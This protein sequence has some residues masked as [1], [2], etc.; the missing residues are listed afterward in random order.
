M[1]DQLGFEVQNAAS[2]TVEGGVLAGAVSFVAATGGSLVSTIT[3]STPLRIAVWDTTYA[4]PSLAKAADKYEIVSA[5]DWDPPPSNTFTIA[6][7]KDGT[8]DI[9]WPTSAGEVWQWDVVVTK[10]MWDD[11]DAKIHLLS[12]GD[13]EI[14]WINVVSDH[15]ATGDGDTDDKAAINLAIGAASSA[16]GGVIYFPAGDYKVSSAA[17]DSIPANTTLI[18]DGP[19]ATIL[20]IEMVSPG[21]GLTLGNRASIQGMAVIGSGADHTIGLNLVSCADGYFSNLEVTDFETGIN[22]SSS[23]TNNRFDHVRVSKTSGTSSVHIATGCPSNIFTACEFSCSGGS[24]VD[25]NGSSTNQSFIACRFTAGDDGIVIEGTVTGVTVVSA[26]D[27]TTTFRSGDGADLVNVVND[28]EIRVAGAAAKIVLG[29][30][31]EISRTDANQLTT[32]DALVVKGLLTG[33]AG[34]TAKVDTDITTSGDGRFQG[35]LDGD[36]DGSVASTDDADLLTITDVKWKREAADVWGTPDSVQIDAGLTVGTHAGGTVVRIDDEDGKVTIGGQYA[37]G[38]DDVDVTSISKLNDTTGITGSDSVVVAAGTDATHVELSESADTT[39]TDYYVN[40]YIRITTDDD[41]E[42]P[43]VI[44]QVR[45]IT[46]YDKDTQIATISPAWTVTPEVGDDYK[47]YTPKLL[48]ENHLKVGT[49]TT[50]RN[51]EVT[52][53]LKVTGDVTENITF[54][55]G[56]MPVS[57][58]RL[59]YK[60]VS[61]DQTDTTNTFFE[62]TGYGWYDVSHSGATNNHIH[63]ITGGTAGDVILITVNP[64]SASDDVVFQHTEADAVT[65]AD[66]LHMSAS[67]DV[68]NRTMGD[69]GE[70]LT[71]MHDGNMWHEISF[72]PNV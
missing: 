53:D 63:R 33:E 28:A 43:A 1:V 26:V 16:S 3:E 66:R 4:S 42:E 72:A 24:C 11:I 13:A 8:D 37:A 59:S 39:T 69:G 38:V 30:D 23:S 19:G 46:D 10:A 18:G 27:G 21:I 48:S 65:T 5:T 14:G 45:L 56:K 62:H 40:H 31:A 50:P 52:G 51:L 57:G 34:I 22:L 7:G 70:T 71:L 61:A 55:E 17:L 29:G 68:N 15:G 41:S 20:S 35:T 6:R 54:A 67:H 58:L 32:P 25:I 49:V 36:I 47:I 2:G 60:A 9:P 44:D 12:G 64:A